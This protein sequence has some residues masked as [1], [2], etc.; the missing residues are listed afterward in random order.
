VDDQE[1][2][3]KILS[4]AKFERQQGVSHPM[5]QGS[6]PLSSK[7]FGMKRGAPAA[8]GH[9]NWQRAWS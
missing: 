6:N 9:R 8:T 4:A 3:A 1:R 5:S 2:S 7:S